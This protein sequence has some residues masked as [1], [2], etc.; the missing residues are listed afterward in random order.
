MSFLDLLQGH[1]SHDET[2]L[3]QPWPEVWDSHIN[4]FQGAF[5]SIDQYCAVILL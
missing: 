2:I 4:L 3:V 5:W 1:Y